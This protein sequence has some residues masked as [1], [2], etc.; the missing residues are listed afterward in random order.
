MDPATE[1]AIEGRYD[2]LVEELKKA[3]D[4]DRLIMEE[5]RKALSEQGLANAFSQ[6]G[7]AMVQSEAKV[8]EARAKLDATIRLVKRAR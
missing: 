4:D 7:Q 6:L 8:A 2:F 1:R 5:W 3:E